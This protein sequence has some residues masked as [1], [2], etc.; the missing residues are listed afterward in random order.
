MHTFLLKNKLKKKILKD[1]T[2]F[3]KMSPLINKMVI[4]KNLVTLK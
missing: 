4:L 3:K 2:D 1:A